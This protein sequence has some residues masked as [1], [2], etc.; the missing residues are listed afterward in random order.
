MENQNLNDN[1]SLGGKWYVINCYSGHEEK[2]K[3][4]L[5]KRIKSLNMS[6]FIFDVRI[7]KQQVMSGR[8]KKMIDVNAFPG[9]IYINMIMNDDT[10]YIVRQ[11]DGVTGLVGSS[12]KGAQPFP[13]AEKEVKK[14]LHLTTEKKPSVKKKE[15]VYKAD[16]EIGDIVKI[17]SGAFEGQ[18]GKVYEIDINKGIA[19]I[20]TEIFGRLTP[21]EVEFSYCQKN[22]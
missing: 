18:E 8:T 4:N 15:K 13:L 9:Y 16:F 5:K 21:V 1:K 12:G 11:T 3:E 14:M 17:L 10:W 19:I 6:D 7:V 2:V 22:V 20:K